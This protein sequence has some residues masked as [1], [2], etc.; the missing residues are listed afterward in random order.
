VIGLAGLV[1]DPLAPAAAPKWA[2]IFILLLLVPF[3]ATRRLSPAAKT[4]LVLASWMCLRSPD[5]IGWLAG[6]AVLLASLSFSVDEARLAASRAGL[7]L[8]LGAS[9]FAL[10]EW[11]FGSH[12]IHGGQGNPDWLGLVLAAA[13]PL[14][15]DELRRPRRPLLLL[16]LSLPISALLLSRSRTAFLAAGLALLVWYRRRWI[17]AP[18]LVAVC[19]LGA[20][21]LAGRVWLWRISAQ[22]ALR[23]PL[24]GAGELSSPFAAVQGELLRALPLGEACRRFVYTASAHNDYLQVAAEA[25]LPALILLLVTLLLAA[26]RSW[27]AGAASLCAIAVAALGDR[28]LAQPPIMILLALILAAAP[29]PE[30]GVV[31]RLGPLLCAAGLALALPAWWAAHLCARSRDENPRASTLALA[32][33]LD[34][35]SGPI[36]FEAGLDAL[37]RHELPSAIAH[38]EK[39]RRNFFQPATEVALG[40]AFLGNGDLERARDVYASLLQLQPGSLRARL[41]LAET[42]RRLGRDNDAEEQRQIA[43][44]LWPGLTERTASLQ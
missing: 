44:R 17:A 3:G 34:P 26:R 13:L 24:V 18:L 7:I 10:V 30:G 28:P 25:G 6:A 41:N 27:P 12:W 42:L 9:L 39:A 29:S 20:H 40:N 33:R 2:A 22:I 5:R 32:E 35:G 31:A 11:I 8:A 19:A 4:F 38:F 23:H 21:A 43:H 16:L 36:A 37:E 14:S 15:I 1:W